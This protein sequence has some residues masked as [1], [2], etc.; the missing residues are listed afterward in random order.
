MAFLT[1][2][3][4]FYY[5]V[6]SLRGIEVDTL[7]LTDSGPLNDRRWMIV[8]SDGK[9]VTQREQP[10]LAQ[11]S[12]QLTAS[13]L[14][15]CLPANP[16]SLDQ[17]VVDVD[18]GSQSIDVTVWRDTVRAIVA[19]PESSDALSRFLGLPVRLVFMP[20]DVARE[21]DTR[22]TE[23]GRRV[24]FAD[25]FPFLITHQASLAALSERIGGDIEMRRFRP[26]IVVS[27]GE[28]FDEDRWKTLT[29]DGL[30]L[31]LV[32]PCSRCIM[33]TVDP[34]SGIKSDD[35]QP[36]RELG[37]FRRT[38]AGVIFGMN[39]VHDGAGPINVGDQF[40][41]SE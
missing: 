9:F 17:S 24:G 40:E 37:A 2:E 36:L 11:V 12:A 20:Q 31:S 39:A 13:G 19:T 6:K 21:A 14:Q 32:K 16:P 38:D 22:Y 35:R 29:R 5:P 41:I 33:T 26:N 30:T 23:P 3:Q 7:D 4:L 25:G 34:W 27:G 10:R 1:V 8:D 18:L 28:A 15:L